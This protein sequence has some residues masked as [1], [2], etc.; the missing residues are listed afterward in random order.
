MLKKLIGLVI[1]AGLLYFVWMQWGADMFKGKP[2]Y[3]PH[4][5][6]GATVEDVEK[7]MGPPL[8]V[9]PNLGRELRKY[10]DKTDNS[11]VTFIYQDGQL[12]EIHP[13]E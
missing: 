13:G 4:V 12:Q 7:D 10:K 2:H 3:G 8:G 11:I 6:I 9:L 5:V 1:L